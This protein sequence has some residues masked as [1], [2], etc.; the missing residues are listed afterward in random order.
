MQMSIKATNTVRAVAAEVP[1]A[2]REFEKLGID[3]CCGGSKTL[4]EACAEAKISIDEALARLQQGLAAPG[5]VAVGTWKAQPLA[6]LVAHI[7][8][9]HHVFV[10]QE[11]PRIEALTE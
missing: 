9:T 2:T 5:P 8:G 7:K 6:D 4:G 3:Y 1:N 10:R 11:C